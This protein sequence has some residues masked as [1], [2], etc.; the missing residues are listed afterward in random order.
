MTFETAGDKIFFP[1]LKILDA[2]VDGDTQV[3][4]WDFVA[5]ASIELYIVRNGEAPFMSGY[6]RGED[7]YKSIIIQSTIPLLKDDRIFAR[8]ILND[9]ISVTEVAVVVRERPGFGPRPFYAI[10]HN[11]NTIQLV[12]EALAAGAN[13]IEPDVNV[14]KESSS[15]L[16]F[17]HIEGDDKD[18]A[19]KQFLMDLHEI[20]VKDNR[21]SLIVFDCKAGAATPEHGLCLLMSIRNYLTY[22]TGVNIIISVSELE[23]A[24]IFDKIRHMLGPREGLMIDEH[25]NPEEISDYFQEAGVENQCYGNGI[26]VPPMFLTG[27]NVMPSMER[28]CALRATTNMPKFLCVWTVKEENFEEEFLQIGVDGIIC[29]DL[30]ELSQCIEHPEFQTLIRLANRI[31]NPFRALNSAYC[32]S[33]YTA[34]RPMAG[35]D[36]NITFTLTGSKGSSEVTVNAGFRSRMERN[37]VSFVTLHSPDLGVLKSVTV[38]RDNAGNAPDWFLDKIVVESF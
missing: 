6:G 10:G 20:A 12:K 27:P 15:E 31:D 33:V 26:S 21:L 29:D 18:P 24:T 32:L 13:A 22:D 2:I 7:L 30:K 28:A 35:T 8:Q 5:N 36:A 34:D 17:S 1:S 16:C 23:H 3:Q 14:Y 9:Q 25:K 19:L 4:M 37:V 38:Q 11:P